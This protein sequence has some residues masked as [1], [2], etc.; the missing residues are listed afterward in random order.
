MLLRA[1]VVWNLEQYLLS[2]DFGAHAYFQPTIHCPQN[3]VDFLPSSMPF[4]DFGAKRH[5]GNIYILHPKPAALTESSW[6]GGCHDRFAE[7]CVGVLNP[8]STFHVSGGHDLVHLK[9]DEVLQTV[10]K[11][12][13][14]VVIGDS[15]GTLSRRGVPT[16]RQGPQRLE[17]VPAYVEN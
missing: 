5:E 4:C 14:Y 8:S 1:Y 9:H 17:A 12:K 6:C 13:A 3:L 10:G 15:P 7:G 16:Q 11:L 2:V